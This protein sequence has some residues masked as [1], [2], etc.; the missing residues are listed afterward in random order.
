MSGSIACRTSCVDSH[1][2]RNQGTVGADRKSICWVHATCFYDVSHLAVTAYQ[3]RA[4]SHFSGQRSQQYG[5][6]YVSRSSTCTLECHPIQDASASRVF[7]L[8]VLSAAPMWQIIKGPSMATVKQAEIHE[9]RFDIKTRDHVALRGV[10]VLAMNRSA[11]LNEL[12]HIHPGSR[13]LT[14]IA[15]ESRHIP[16]FLIKRQP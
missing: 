10:S 6:K 1:D 8:R 13:V 15:V 3:R 2:S 14:A 7:R 4:V 5:L 9:Y 12:R 16:Q 11:A